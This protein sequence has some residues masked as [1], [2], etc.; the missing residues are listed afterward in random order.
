MKEPCFVKKQR[1]SRHLNPPMPAICPSFTKFVSCVAPPNII[2]PFSIVCVMPARKRRKHTI[3]FSPPDKCEERGSSH[4]FTQSGINVSFLVAVFIF[5]AWCQ[6]QF[7]L[8]NGRMLLHQMELQLRRC[9]N[10][11]LCGKVLM[12]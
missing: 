7:C 4:A 6:L 10:D 11:R 3:R 1:G 8:Q 2:S 9:G 5:I 12:A